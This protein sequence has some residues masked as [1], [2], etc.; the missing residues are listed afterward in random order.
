MVIG[1]DI[2]NTITNTYLTTQKY[3]SIYDNTYTD[4]H[5]LPEER[6]TEFL[7]LYIENIMTEC[8]L[9]DYVKEALEYFKQNNYKIILITARNNKYSPK[10]KTITTNYLAKYNLPYDKI[11]FDDEEQENK[12]LSANQEHVSLF[13]DDKETNLDNIAKYNIECLLFDNQKHPQNCSKYKTFS[14]WRDIIEYI[15]RKD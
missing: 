12:G 13:I 8:S 3:L 15:K 4:W 7:N 11:I 9:K 6:K 2:D 14:N 1:I 5:N 10:V